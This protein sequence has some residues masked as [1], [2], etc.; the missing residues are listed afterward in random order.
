MLASTMINWHW[1]A[2]LISYLSKRVTVMPF[3]NIPELLENTNFRIALFPGS[4][5]E[6]AF[7][8]ATDH[9][10]KRAWK[11]RIQPFLHEYK[12]HNGNM[13]QYPLADSSIALYNTDFNLRYSIQLS[14]Y[15]HHTRLF[16]EIYLSIRTADLLP[17]Q[18]S[19]TIN[20]LLMDFKRT[21]L[22]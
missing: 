12:D 8:Y 9:H 10:L 3:N 7:E 13:T 1:Q 4:Y 18:P 21:R 16:S 5:S 2:M 20:H 22:I 19:M 14:K 17:H 15:H 6:N 11:E